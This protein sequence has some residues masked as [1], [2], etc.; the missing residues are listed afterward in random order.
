MRILL[1]AIVL[2]FPVLDLLVTVRFARWS[3]VSIWVW[4]GL[5]MIGGFLILRSERGTFRDHIVAS[6]HGGQPLLRGLF[7]SGRR[8]LA[9]ILLLL[10]GVISDLIAL[11]LLALPLNVGRGLGTAAAGP[12]PAV[13]R[14]TLDGEYRRID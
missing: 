13:Q 5:S 14:R 6:L 10:P 3:G 4:L 9:G 8:I 2:A 1:L 12:T 7:D 11:A